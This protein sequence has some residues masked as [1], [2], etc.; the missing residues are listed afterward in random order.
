MIEGESPEAYF[1][2]AEASHPMS[3]AMR[4]LLERG[5]RY[6]ELREEAIAELREG[7]ED[8]AASG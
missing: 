6:P 3:V 2:A 7:N 1:A 4:S 8:P 5:G